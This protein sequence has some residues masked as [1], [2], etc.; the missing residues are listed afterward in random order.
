MGKPIPPQEP[1]VIGGSKKSVA[2]SPKINFI[3]SGGLGVATNNGDSKESE[4]DDTPEPDIQPVGQDYIEEIKSDDG[5]V[6]E[7][8]Y[9]FFQ[10]I[11]L[12][13]ELMPVINYKITREFIYPYIQFTK[14]FPYNLFLVE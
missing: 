3:Q 7:K 13:I 14:F 12:Q 1:E 6:C 5:K 4:E 9:N 2:A 8:S 10:K 11:L